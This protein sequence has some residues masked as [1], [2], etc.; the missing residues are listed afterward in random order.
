MPLARFIREQ[1]RLKGWL[2][3]QMG[4]GR[5]RMSRILSGE[6]SMTLEEAAKAASALGVPIEALL[7]VPAETFEGGGS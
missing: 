5:E 3:E 1:G 6:R 2:A 7:P 4:C